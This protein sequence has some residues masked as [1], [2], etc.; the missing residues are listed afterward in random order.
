VLAVLAPF[1]TAA[2]RD[3]EATPPYVLTHLW[4][5]EYALLRGDLRAAASEPMRAMSGA[6]DPSTT[7]IETAQTLA[8]S[9]AVRANNLPALPAG[10]SPRAYLH[11]AVMDAVALARGRTD[12][13]GHAPSTVG[14]D[15][16][17]AT[18][19]AVLTS[20]VAGDAGPLADLAERCALRAMRGADTLFGIWP[21]L[22]RDRARV[23][24]Q[25]SYAAPD[26]FVDL[27]PFDV[28]RRALLR[29]DLA[30]LV[31]DTATAAAWQG[32]LDRHLA[33]LA[34]HD[35]AIAMILWGLL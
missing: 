30:S 28:M 31:G 12:Y 33:A 26:L 25:I 22:Q 29:R 17:G 16:E 34:D 18:M 7:A 11:P 9:L 2:R 6:T 20:A 24:T 32:V 15:C 14:H 21:R 3:A 8:V 35:A 13:L 5:G 19:Q 23:A 1:A 10:F 4:Q 27:R